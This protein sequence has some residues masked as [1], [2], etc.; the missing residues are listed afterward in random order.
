M[1]SPGLIQRQSQSLVMTPQLRQAIAMLQLGHQEL[2]QSLQQIAEL[3]PLLVL[4]PTDTVA[5]PKPDETPD[6]HDDDPDRFT[7]G[8]EQPETAA[9]GPSLHDDLS[10]QIHLTFPE[11]QDRAAALYLLASLDD[12]G[13][14]PEPVSDIACALSMETADLESIRH[15]LMR[16]DP[17]GLFC[18]SLEECLAVQLE[19]RGRLDPAMKI[20][21]A[22]LD[23]LARRDWRILRQKCQ[24]EQDDLLDMLAEIQTLNPRPGFDPRHPV[25]PIQPDLTVRRN[26]DGFRLTF[27]QRALPRCHVD[28]DIQRHI[29]SN[30]EAGRQLQTYASEASAV[31]RALEMRRQTILKV[32][33]E[34]IRQ[35]AAF[36]E[37]GIS[38]L[39]PLTMREL[40]TTTDVHESTISR[41]VNGKYMD[42]P[43]GIVPLRM[44]FSTALQASDGSVQSASAIQ[45]RLRALIAAEG[46][47]IL[48]D[49]A[50]TTL[51]QKE[52]FAI[53]RRT[54]AK[55]R[56]GLGIAKS[57]QRRRLKKTS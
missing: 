54:V 9:P 10:S 23:L 38:A 55:Y 22:N 17:A 45:H 26:G 41:V 18:R 36:F 40:A 11:H 31:I 33:A 30:S 28:T 34:I 25:T 35:Q 24:L 4:E 29:D 13:R 44:F 3:N 52:G 5:L 16:L 46:D 2:T 8:A 53:Q 27:N 32:G 51:L 21:L 14:L 12:A 19:Q 39:R 48:S 50:L 15:I 6:Y 56:E 47:D 7:S 43:R 49:D 57:S 20:L 1:L 37:D 42:T